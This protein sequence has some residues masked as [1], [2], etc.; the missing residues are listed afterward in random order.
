MFDCV[1]NFT[2]TIGREFV[3]NMAMDDHYLNCQ[4]NYEVR[5]KDYYQMNLKLAKE[6]LHIPLTLKTIDQDAPNI[7]DLIYKDK[8][9]DRAI[10]AAGENDDIMHKTMHVIALTREWIN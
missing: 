3:P 8:I 6:F 7:L 5:I 1:E 9:Y 2:H 4:D 10:V